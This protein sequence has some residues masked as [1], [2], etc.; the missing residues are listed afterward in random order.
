MRR[1]GRAGTQLGFYCL[2]L[3]SQFRK[4]RT[5]SLRSLL[6]TLQSGPLYSGDR[7]NL[8]V[9]PLANVEM[10]LKRPANHASTLPRSP[11]RRPSCFREIG[12]R[13][14]APLDAGRRLRLPSQARARPAPFCWP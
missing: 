9:T 12:L 5:G 4:P 14:A 13:Q 3:R 10:S 6:G 7:R 11:T 2:D 8:G 1:D